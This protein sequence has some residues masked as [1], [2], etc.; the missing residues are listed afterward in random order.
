MYCLYLLSY[1]SNYTRNPSNPS[2][3]HA[4]AAPKHPSC[5]SSNRTSSFT[6][7]TQTLVV[8]LILFLAAL[9]NFPAIRCWPGTLTEEKDTIRQQQYF[10]WPLDDEIAKIRVQSTESIAHCHFFFWA[11]S[12]PGFWF[13]LTPPKGKAPSPPLVRYL[14]RR[15]MG[16]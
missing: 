5:Q 1:Q 10:S 2:V 4:K 6:H 7:S 9:P 14:R 16:F 15:P 13:D 12:L 8:F 3:H 11:S